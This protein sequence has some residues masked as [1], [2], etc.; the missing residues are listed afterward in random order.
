MA[1][2]TARKRATV[3]DVAALAGVGHPSVSIVLNGAKSGMHVSEATRQR[4][5]EAAAELDYQPNTSARAMKTGRFGCVGLLTS[6][7]PRR[8]NVQSEM[9][10]GI[11]DELAAHDL[12]L[13]LVQAPDVSLTDEA[14]V[15]RL[16][17]EWM[18]DGLLIGYNVGIPPLMTELITRNCIPSVWLN[19]EQEFDCVRPDDEEGTYQATRH[20]LELG[21]RRIAYVSIARPIHYSVAARER[22]YRKAM[23]E[24]GLAAQVHEEDLELPARAKYEQVRG[25]LA[26][27]VRPTAMLFYGG[28]S[29]VLTFYAAERMGLRVPDQLSLISTGE[30]PIPCL[31]STLDT[32]II[33]FYEIG[34][35]AVRQLLEKIEHPAQ[36][37]PTRTLPFTLVPG[38][39]VAHAPA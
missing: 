2:S 39:T 19:A 15:P 20:L 10:R 17:R 9:Q 7:E 36:S 14:A 35:V 29:A 32:M 28:E 18:V 5:I 37:L 21:H 1:Q 4:I 6:T 11:H 27:A 16:L 31:H 23:D 13:M 25:W 22:G 8:S 38:E 3:K 30:S 12:H 26:P 24:A 33:P 34:R